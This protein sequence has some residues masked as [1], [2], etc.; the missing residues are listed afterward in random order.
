MEFVLANELDY[1]VHVT[2]IE[3]STLSIEIVLS[4]GQ[5]PVPTGRVLRREM[6]GPGE[7]LAM[8][9]LGR[10]KLI[11]DR[12]RFPDIDAKRQRGK[13]KAEIDFV[14]VTLRPKEGHP[15]EAT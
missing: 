3:H 8:K 7:G 14:L 12:T 2:V 6:L 15:E 10:L 4:L 5:V 1:P 13:T 9:G 11:L